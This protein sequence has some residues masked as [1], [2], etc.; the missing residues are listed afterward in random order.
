[1][2]LPQDHAVIFDAHVTLEFVECPSPQ[3]LLVARAPLQLLNVVPDV[4]HVEIAVL[5]IDI[6]CLLVLLGGVLILA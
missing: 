1:M 5:C 6:G 4:N 3:Q 2:V